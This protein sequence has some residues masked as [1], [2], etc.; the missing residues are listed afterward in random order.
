MIDRSDMATDEQIEELKALFIEHRPLIDRYSDTL[1]A[2]I[3]E[4]QDSRNE[5]YSMSYEHT[6]CN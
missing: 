6:L 3:E 2:I 5:Q 4:V 1:L